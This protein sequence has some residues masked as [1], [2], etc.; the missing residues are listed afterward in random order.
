MERSDRRRFV[1]LCPPPIPLNPPSPTLT[2]RDPPKHAAD[3]AGSTATAT[4]RHGVSA[5]ARLTPRDAP[6]TLVASGDDAGAVSLWRCDAPPDAASPPHVRRVA[7]APRDPRD[8][9]IAAL[10]SASASASASAPHSFVGDVDGAIRVLDPATLRAILRV[11]AAHAGACRAI[12]PHPSNPNLVASAGDDGAARVWDFRVG[13]EGA[14]RDFRLRLAS[15]RSGEDAR[16]GTGRAAAIAWCASAG[17][18]VAVGYESGAVCFLEAAMGLAT[19]GVVVAHD[20]A[21]RAVAWD[22]SRGALAS[23][24]DDGTT[25][26]HVGELPATC[27]RALH[28]GWYARCVAW[29]GEGGRLLSGGWDGDVVVAEVVKTR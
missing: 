25:A 11:D 1:A 27:R 7:I 15:E 22:A 10:A 3:R 20:D 9:P 6:E 21:V 13:R 19:R 2:P 8:A 18:A 17:D 16:P 12:A 4:T 24:G 23:C 26:I 28:G 5:V 29:D 14:L